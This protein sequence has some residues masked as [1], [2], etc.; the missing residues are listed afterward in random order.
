MGVV[1]VPYT[2][3]RVPNEQA[4]AV[5]AQDKKQMLIG[6][7]VWS[8]LM[9]VM[10]FKDLQVQG[11]TSAFY[12][13]LL[14]RLGFTVLSVV[15]A[16]M[17]MVFVNQRQVFNLLIAI[18]GIFAV[19]VSAVIIS[20]NPI[21]NAST[22]LVDL[23][24]ILSFYYFIPHSLV[25]RIIPPLLLTF[26]DF[27]R[28]L[29]QPSLYTRQEISAVMFSFTITNVIGI[30]VSMV[31]FSR[32]HRD[33]Q[34]KAEDHRV[35]AELVRLA[36]TDS[37][38]GAFNRRRMIEIAGEAIY[39]YHRYRRPFSLLVMDLDGFKQ[40]NDTFGHQQGDLTLIEFVR[41]ISSEKRESD[42]LGRMGGDEFCL[43][44]PETARA[45]AARMAERIL[46]RCSAL[47][48][49]HNTA[50]SLVVSVSIG[51]T[52]VQPADQSID[53]LISRGDTALYSAKNSGKNRYV[54]I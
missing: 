30:L 38:T 3:Q 21:Q 27:A 23:V 15:I 35:R 19:I 22:Y 39:R 45:E 44:L 12:L 1:K 6:I 9:L 5:L 40:I 26:F 24:A 33:D 25:L 13:L 41:M 43:V 34:T 42:T 32:Q 37:L 4:N 10:F 14:V 20:A 8:I 36:T 28:L 7:A 50:L 29:G 46:R 54:V 16:W 51:I 53:A 52:E 17:V 11:D 48:I 18:W 47:A 31:A 49:N 2:T